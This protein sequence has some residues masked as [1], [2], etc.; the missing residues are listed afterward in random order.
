MNRSCSRSACRHS[1]IASVA[2]SASA[3]GFIDLGHLPDLSRG[4]EGVLELRLGL[5][6][7]VVLQII[8]R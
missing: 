3:A 5:G 4:G 1:K 7:G 8:R 2:V 6:G